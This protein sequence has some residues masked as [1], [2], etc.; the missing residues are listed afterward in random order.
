MVLPFHFILCNY[1]EAF[2]LNAFVMG[3]CFTL[4]NSPLFHKIE[5]K[6]SNVCGVAVLLAEYTILLCFQ[7]SAL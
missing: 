5:D 2:G 3:N 7:E 4:R 1:F 6:L